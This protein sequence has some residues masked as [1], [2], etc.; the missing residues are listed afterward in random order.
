MYFVCP[1]FAATIAAII[2]GCKSIAFWIDSWLN[3]S[4]VDF[5]SLIKPPI[6]FREGFRDWY[7]SY[8]PPGLF[9]QVLFTLWSRIMQSG[10][11]T[12]NPPLSSSVLPV[13]SGI[14][15]L[16]PTRPAP[17]HT[18]IPNLAQASRTVFVWA[19]RSLSTITVFTPASWRMGPTWEELSHESMQNAI[20]LQP[21]GYYSY[22]GCNGG[23][24]KV[25]EQ[26]LL[27]LN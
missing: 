22:S 21:K 8:R 7:V 23:S 11:F 24:N 9:F 25:H 17:G 12:G 10:E 6:V 13:N 14:S 1:P 2:F 5:I 27:V 19:F 4:H 3:L 20:D 26:W 16:S 15:F 18:L